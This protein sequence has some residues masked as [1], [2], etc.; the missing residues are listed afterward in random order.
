M[1]ISVILKMAKVA[2]FGEG[3]KVAYS[4]LWKQACKILLCQSE[5]KV[6]IFSLMFI[7]WLSYL[8]KQLCNKSACPKLVTTSKE[9][10]ME[11]KLSDSW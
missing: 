2:S 3:G 10:G 7:S 4:L 5:L 8:L 1:T 6:V 9:E 11:P